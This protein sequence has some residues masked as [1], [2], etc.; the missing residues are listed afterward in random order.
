M[1]KTQNLIALA[2]DVGERRIGLA[3]SDPSG[4]LATPL[5]TIQRTQEPADVDEVLRLAEEHDV[6]K[7]VVGLPLELSG[8]RG[9]QAGRVMAF[10]RALIGRT[11][12]PVETVDER[13]STVEA[14]RRLRDSG[15]EPSK[16]RARLDAAAAAVI[17]E[18]Y[19]DARREPR[20]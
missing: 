1:R 10:A 16:D 7:M 3:L 18:S 19:L 20:L 13:Y 4:L 8:R 14:E 17:L 5:A 6:E 9:P 11:E 12:L 15:V 2:L